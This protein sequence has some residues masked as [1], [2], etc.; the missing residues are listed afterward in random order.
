MTQETTKPQ[1]APDNPYFKHIETAFRSKDWKDVPDKINQTAQEIS[2][3]C[4][5]EEAQ[6][7]DWDCRFNAKGAYLDAKKH[8]KKHG[9]YKSLSDFSMDVAFLFVTIVAGLSIVEQD[10]EY[11]GHQ[12]T[13]WKS[14]GAALT[15]SILTG[16]G[17]VYSQKRQEAAM[18]GNKFLIEA[19]NATK[20]I[21]KT[22]QEKQKV[23]A[24]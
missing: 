3:N 19:H 1:K 18:K 14:A 21:L 12:N 9:I 6:K 11:D 23:R 4:T 22:M 16:I 24:D 2:Q 10:H 13:A 7:I 8:E 5:Y 20:K 15:L 17:S